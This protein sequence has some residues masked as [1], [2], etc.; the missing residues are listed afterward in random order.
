[1]VRKISFSIISVTILVIGISA[2]SKLGYWERSAAIFT[3][4][5]QTSFSGRAGNNHERTGELK[6]REERYRSDDGA[7]RSG[8]DEDLEDAPKLNK[9]IPDSLNQQVVNPEIEQPEEGTFSGGMRKGEGHRGVDSHRGMIINLGKVSLFLAVFAS[10][11]IIAIYVDRG[12]LLIQKRK[13]G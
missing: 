3:F 8:S 12:I 1:M 10:F 4:S 2:F 7:K 5:Q 11:A 9:K 6:I 13:A